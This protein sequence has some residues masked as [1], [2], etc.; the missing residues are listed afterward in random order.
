MN[1]NYL[2]PA[3]FKKLGWFLFIPSVILGFLTVL[4]DWEPSFLDIKV[5]A[6]FIDEF[7][8]ENKLAEIVTN[9]VLNEILGALVIVSG[10]IVAFSKEK[11]EDEFIA[12]IRLRSLVWATY[13]NYFVLLFAVLFI[14]ELSFAWVMIFNMFTILLFFIVRFNFSLLKLQKS[15]V[16]EE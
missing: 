16:N 10:L 3:R 6:L 11:E 5:P 9:N 7:I 2:L 12:S 13:F 4:N 15:G 8:G 1:K 14:Y